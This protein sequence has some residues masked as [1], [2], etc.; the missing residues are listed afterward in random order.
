MP[1]VFTPLPDVTVHVMQAELVGGE[2]ANRK[3]PAAT[4]LRLGIG[5]CLPE[6]ISRP[7]A[8]PRRILP[9]GFGQESV[10]F[11]RL[12]R[13][14]SCILLRVVPR[15]VDHRSVGMSPAFGPV[16]APTRGHTRLPL[17]DRHLELADR[18]R[19]LD[20]HPVRWPLAVVLL[21]AHHE[22]ARRYNHHFGAIRT[23]AK[24]LTGIFCL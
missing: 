5:D 21:R 11:P 13:E 10:G 23:V 16:P 4:I 18:K 20:R 9:L 6:R 7:R 19:P 24:G 2:R 8:S 22:L 12:A 1:V 17:G 14:P 15:Y 3:H